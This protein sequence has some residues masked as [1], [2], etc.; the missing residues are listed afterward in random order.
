MDNFVSKVTESLYRECKCPT[1]SQK[2][3]IERNEEM[4]KSHELINRFRNIM[5]D[6]LKM[7]P[8]RC[9][10]GIYEFMK[11]INHTSEK[12]LFID[13]L[14]RLNLIHEQGHKSEKCITLIPLICSGIIPEFEKLEYRFDTNPLKIEANLGI[15]PSYLRA[16]IFKILF[17]KGWSVKSSGPQS[18]QGDTFLFSKVAHTILIHF[19][20]SEQNTSI[21]CLYSLKTCEKTTDSLAV[22]DY[23]E[24]RKNI[25]NELKMCKQRT[26]NENDSVKY[27][28]KPKP[29]H[30]DIETAI[31]EEEGQWIE[32]DLKNV[33][34]KIA[35]NMT[36]YLYPWFSSEVII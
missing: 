3:K 13:N 9:T 34:Q 31:T 21:V 17:D 11:R 35:S 15:I 12:R 22:Q 18:C 26:E 30:L 25:G 20:S 16:N 5:T 36:R 14:A 1:S 7:S 2:V 33:H 6:I 27:Y 23:E 4:L 8:V 19:K 28:V 10:I 29:D 32:V 24:L